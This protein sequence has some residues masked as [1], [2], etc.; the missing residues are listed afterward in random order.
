[1]ERVTTAAHQ[2][3]RVRDT[4]IGASGGCP[5]V[6]CQGLTQGPSDTGSLGHNLLGLN[7]LYDNQNFK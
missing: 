6:S 2:L 7:Q 5:S 3:K 1:M 4:L